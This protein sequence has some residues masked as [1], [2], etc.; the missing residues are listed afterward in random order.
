MDP[1]LKPS[2]ASAAQDVFVR[3]LTGAELGGQLPLQGQHPRAWP[4]ELQPWQ[5]RVRPGIWDHGKDG[6]AGLSV[7]AVSGGLRPQH[8]LR[9]PAP[10]GKVLPFILV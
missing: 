9:E 5:A 10:S 6:T 2:L 4:G 7:R 8:L 1:P 3:L